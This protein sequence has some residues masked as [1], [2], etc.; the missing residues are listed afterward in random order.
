M[1]QFTLHYFITTCRWGLGN[2]ASNKILNA[3]NSIV[4]I[5]LNKPKSYPSVKLF[6]ENKDFTIQ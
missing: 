1:A 4:Q 5:I 6:E 3:Q 2:V